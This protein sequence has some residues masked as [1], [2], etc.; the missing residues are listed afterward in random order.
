MEALAKDCRFVTAAGGT[1][2]TARLMELEERLRPHGF[3]RCHRS[4]LVN[5][6]YIFSLDDRTVLPVY[7]RILS[8]SRGRAEELRESFFAYV[9]GG[10]A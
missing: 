1:I 2:L 3:V 7:R 6:Q 9:N 5:C 8:P 4:Y 10:S